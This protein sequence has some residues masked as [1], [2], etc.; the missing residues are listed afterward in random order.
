M[1]SSI[2]THNSTIVPSIINHVIYF[3]WGGS[4]SY[5]HLQ[6]TYSWSNFQAWHQHIWY[7]VKNS[8]FTK[9]NMVLAT[10]FPSPIFFLIRGMNKQH[11][12]TT[13]NNNRCL[14]LLLKTNQINPT[15]IMIAIIT[16]LI[17]T[18]QS[19]TTTTIIMPCYNNTKASLSIQFHHQH[20]SM[21]LQYYST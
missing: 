8:H 3:L 5:W 16:T 7:I 4:K 18:N 2:S 10:C 1:L 20:M 9:F 12:F 21:L 17:P 14:L 19:A 13:D 15:S 11:I 6:N